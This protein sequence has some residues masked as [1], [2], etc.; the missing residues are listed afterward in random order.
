MTNFEFY[1]DRIKELGT[2]NFALDKNDKLHNCW[3][4]N[5]HDCIFSDYNNKDKGGKCGERCVDF[6]YAEHREKHKLTKK[7]RLFCELVSTGYIAR[8]RDSDIYY[9]KNKPH[10]K[11]GIWD[12]ETESYFE[13]AALEPGIKLKFD[14]IS[15]NDEYPWSIDELLS[16]EVIEE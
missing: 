4:I 2:F 16:L 14:F 5:C 8:D 13:L 6:L 9:Y 15:W 10:K 3:D 11:G 1:K 7:E 12:D